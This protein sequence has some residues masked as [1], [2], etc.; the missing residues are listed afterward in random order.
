MPKYDADYKPQLRSVEANL[1]EIDSGCGFELTDPQR[2]A[3]GAMTV[4]EPTLFILSRF[5]GAHSIEDVRVA[6]ANEYGQS[7]SIEQITELLD[8][9]E[10]AHFLA[11]ES[12]D[13]YYKSLVTQYRAQASRVMGN[14]EE[15]GLDSD[16]SSA[17]QGVIDAS[18][19]SWRTRDRVMGL[20]APHLDYERGTPC[21][22]AAYAALLDQPPPSR[23]VFLGTNHFG[24]AL[25]VVATGKD[26]ETPLGVTRTDLEF[27]EKV[28]A[29]VGDL[30]A[31]EFDHQREHSVEL[32]LLLCQRLWGAQSFEMAA[33]LCPD[34]CGPTRT[35][36][37]DGHGVDMKT[38]ATELGS[39]IGDD[40]RWTLVVAGADLSHVGRHFGDQQELDDAFLDQVRRKDLSA[41]DHVSA[42]QPEAFIDLLCRTGNETRVCSAGCISA[43]L[44]ALPDADVHVL[45]YHQAVDPARTVGVTC[46]AAVVTQPRS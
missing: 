40:D 17:L 26:F 10:Q 37:L 30:R 33:F 15:L 24:Q 18:P 11:G 23:V 19:T 36:P 28:E 20:I 21:Y 1:I 14:V 32:Q 6:F 8:T 46:A 16:P 7:L 5:D 4:N 13:R 12:F 2:L 38:F 3:T 29:R 34:P 35:A 9:L 42:N 25:S 31:H 22:S 45:R 39:V 27:L 43:L 44:F 41:L